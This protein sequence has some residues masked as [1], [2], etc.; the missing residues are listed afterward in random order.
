MDA[1]LQRI[2]TEIA[3]LEDQMEQA[4]KRGQRQR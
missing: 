2:E 4:R 1:M 3:V